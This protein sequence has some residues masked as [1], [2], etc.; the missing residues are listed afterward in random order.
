VKENI[1][2]MARA[3]QNP[4]YLQKL[5]IIQQQLNEVKPSR[6]DHIA[7]VIDGLS[8]AIRNGQPVEEFIKLY[9]Q[10]CQDELLHDHKHADQEETKGTSDKIDLNTLGSRG[11]NCLHAACA[12]GNIAIAKYLLNTKRVNPNISGID[13]WTPL[14]IAAQTGIFELVDVLIQDPRTKI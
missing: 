10:L 7:T 2:K 14:E 5:G 1:S 4:R 9:N 13:Y 8:D 6:A 11:F 3:G 12:S